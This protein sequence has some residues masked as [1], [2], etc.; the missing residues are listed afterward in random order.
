MLRCTQFTCSPSDLLRTL[1]QLAPMLIFPDML[2]GAPSTLRSHQA[3]DLSLQSN[4]PPKLR[5][6]WVISTW[7]THPRDLL[8]MCSQDMPCSASSWSCPQFSHYTQVHCPC[9]G[10]LKLSLH[11]VL[12]LIDTS[13]GCAH[14][15]VPGHVLRI[16]HH[17]KSKY[18]SASVSYMSFAGKG[19]FSDTR[20]SPIMKGT[21]WS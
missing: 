15:L 13:P 17:A 3:H 9:S 14:A 6:A 7:Y 1:H 21:P 2:S 10:S 11:D 19:W 18:L 12:S 20:S 8:R 4:A 5:F 16:S